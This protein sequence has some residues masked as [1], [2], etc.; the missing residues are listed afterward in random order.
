MVP[1]SIKIQARERQRRIQTTSKRLFSAREYL[2][3]A[4]IDVILNHSSDTKA[5][6]FLILSVL[7]MIYIASVT[8]YQFQEAKAQL[9]IE[10]DAF[11]Y[12]KGSFCLYDHKNHE[13]ECSGSDGPFP[14]GILFEI[15]QIAEGEEFK[16][17]D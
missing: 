5:T 6:F 11:P 9:R 4:G 8:A 1:Q 7:T 13:L 12:D 16:V 10:M 17:C 15:N 14:A 3:I 2:S